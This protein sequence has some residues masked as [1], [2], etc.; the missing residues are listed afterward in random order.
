ME[1]FHV[2]GACPCHAHE[3]VAIG[4]GLAGLIAAI[5][6]AICRIRSGVA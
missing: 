3:A 6:Y 1:V 4:S 5:R 2:F